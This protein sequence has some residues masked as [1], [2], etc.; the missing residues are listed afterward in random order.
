VRWP[1]KRYCGCFRKAK[2]MENVENVTEKNELNMSQTT[3]SCGLIWK[4]ASN[5]I[6][7]I[8]NGLETA[9]FGLSNPFLD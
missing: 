6:L 7:L 9:L 4:R 8:E 1:T 2:K 5:F 3:L